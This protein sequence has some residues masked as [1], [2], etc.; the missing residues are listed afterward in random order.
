MVETGDG[1]NGP[2]SILYSIS[3]PGTGV[4]VGNSNAAAQ[5]LGIAV[6]IGDEGNITTFTILP[7]AHA[8]GPAVPP[9]LLPHNAVKT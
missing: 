5:V 9:A 1:E 6:S 7:A 2:P 4:T 8:T 3:N